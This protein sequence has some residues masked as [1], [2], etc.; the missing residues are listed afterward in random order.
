MVQK[1]EEGI[2]STRE[3][4][5]LAPG[6]Q[7]LMIVVSD[8]FNLKINEVCSFE[9][10]IWY[11]WYS[12]TLHKSLQRGWWCK[13]PCDPWGPHANNTEGIGWN[14]RFL[15][16][17]QSWTVPSWPYW[18]RNGLLHGFFSC[19]KGDTVVI[20]ELR[21]PDLGEP[22]TKLWLRNHSWVFSF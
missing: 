2:S 11:H 19:I 22:L 4:G 8:F 14:S 12:L 5:F 15:I 18:L 3:A 1:Q 16:R 6:T 21:T 10:I 17:Q 7:T 20:S 13:W 9:M